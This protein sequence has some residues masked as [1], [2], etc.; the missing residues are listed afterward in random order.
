[1]AFGLAAAPALLGEAEG[2]ARAQAPLALVI[3][4]T[5]ELALQV[6]ASWPWL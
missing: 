1:V 3:A 5:R 4:P 6:T 2:F